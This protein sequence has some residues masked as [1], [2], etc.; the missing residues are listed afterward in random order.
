MP[1]DSLEPKDLATWRKER[2]AEMIA[3]RKALPREDQRRSDE[4]IAQL[5]LEGFPLLRGLTVGFYW[6]FNGEVEPRVAMHRLREL[7]SKTALPVVV[8]KATPLEFREWTPGVATVPGVFGLPVPQ[9]PRVVP[10]ALLMPPVGVDTRGFRLGYGGGYFDRTLASLSPQPLKIGLAREL[11]L[12]ETIYPQPY[13]IPMDFVVMESGIHEVTDRGL[14]LIDVAAADERARRIR[15][16]RAPLSKEELAA[17]LNMLLEAERAGAKVVSAFLDEI[18]L[19]AE[20]R[21]RLLEVQRDESRNCAVL[22]DQLRR[23]GVEP[24]KATGDFLQKALAVQGHRARL[25]FLNRGQAWVARRIASN[26]PRICD[27]SLREEMR[28]MHDSHVV[29]IADCDGLLGTLAP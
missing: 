3:R 26:L 9:T 18:P 13:D 29:N 20:A 21:A 5:L 2:R 19:P 12:M 28:K 15:A 25:E 27:A 4:R 7:G 6:P 11:S 1:M 22:L 14:Q 16:E 24:S 8:A 10:D 23:L 17:F